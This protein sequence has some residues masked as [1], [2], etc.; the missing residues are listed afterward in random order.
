VSESLPGVVLGT[1]AYMS[2]EQVEGSEIDARSDLMAERL[3]VHVPA[4]IKW[5]PSATPTSYT[6]AMLG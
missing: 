1:T 2:P 6:V 5:Y 3:A 4:A